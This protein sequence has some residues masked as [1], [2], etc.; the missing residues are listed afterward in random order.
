MDVVSGGSA[1]E[2]IVIGVLIIA[3]GIAYLI[4]LVKRKL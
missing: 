1:T 2:E 4:W 3:S